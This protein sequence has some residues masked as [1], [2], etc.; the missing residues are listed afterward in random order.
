MYSD[1]GKENRTHHNRIIHNPQPYNPLNPQIRIH[2]T[3]RSTLRRHRR[4]AHGVEGRHRCRADK[5]INFVVRRRVGACEPT[6]GI[7]VPGRSSDE[8]TRGLDGFAHGK[9]V[10]VC[11]EEVGI[12]ERGIEWVARIY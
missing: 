12:N 2:N 7:P 10:E 1:K 4:R 11:G 8:P 6:S 3:P 5:S 9:D